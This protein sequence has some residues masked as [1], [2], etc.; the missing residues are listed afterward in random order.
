VYN[1]L[2]GGLLTGKYDRSKLPA[3]NTRFGLKTIGKRYLER[4]WSDLNFEAIEGLQ[5]TAQ[6]A[7]RSLNHLA[8]AW[9]L[10]NKTVTSVICG[11]SSTKQL[12]QNLEAIDTKLTNEELIACDEIW[13][14]L[15]PPRFSYGR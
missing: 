11:C 10:D 3:S 14:R 2:A 1:P 8:L 5:L 13:Q 12:R 15:S 6:K 9:I 4:Y 7:G